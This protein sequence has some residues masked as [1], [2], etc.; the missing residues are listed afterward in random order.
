MV[1]SVCFSPDGKYVAS[2]SWDN[3]V[4]ISAVADG[5]LVQEVEVCVGVGC[6][7]CMENCVSL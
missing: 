7:K 6:C 5:S 2:G 3:T 4:R 1:T